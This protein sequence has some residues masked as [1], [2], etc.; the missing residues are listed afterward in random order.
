MIKHR[1]GDDATV[2][3][4]RICGGHRVQRPWIDPN[5]PIQL[6]RPCRIGHR[7]AVTTQYEQMD[8]PKDADDETDTSDWRGH[9]EIVVAR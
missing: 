8:L 9:F 6:Y 1:D 4:F 2:Q 5:A 3:L 7:V